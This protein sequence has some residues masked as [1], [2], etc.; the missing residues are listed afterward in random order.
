MLSITSPHSASRK[1]AVFLP[2]AVLHLG[3]ERFGTG[4]LPD[5]WLRV[6]LEVSLGQSL[7]DDF[8][9]RI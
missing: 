9:T 1:D 3:P 4:G 6:L 7:A 5:V 2:A 8:V